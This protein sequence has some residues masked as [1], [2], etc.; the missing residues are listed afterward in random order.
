MS[1]N[2]AGGSEEV[3]AAAATR[4]EKDAQKY[5]EEIEHINE[6]I[7]GCTDETEQRHLQRLLSE[8]KRTLAAVLTAAQKYGR[9]AD[10]PV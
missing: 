5:R 3:A 2:R 4:L 7:K 6:Q 8:A 1:V 10:E 9:A